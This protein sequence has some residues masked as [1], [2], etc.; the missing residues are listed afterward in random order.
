M[1]IADL[2]GFFGIWMAL[3]GFAICLHLICPPPAPWWRF[4]HPD[5]GLLGGLVFC[6]C[7]LAG[8]VLLAGAWLFLAW[9]PL[10]Q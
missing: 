7:V 4:W 2:I 3:H 10:F 1:N 6:D 8:A 9:L 5:S